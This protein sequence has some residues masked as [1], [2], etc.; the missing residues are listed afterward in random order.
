MSPTGMR[1]D[2]QTIQQSVAAGSV[3]VASTGTGPFEQIL[4]DGRHALHADEPVPVGGSDA[5][6]G[7]YELLLMAL[8][9]CTSMTVNLY[10]ARKSGLLNRSSCGF[11]TNGSMP[12]T[13]QIVRIQSRGLIAFC[14]ALNWLGH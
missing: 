2:L 11:D 5:G 10:A 8:G 1:Q 7:P 9:N 4:L 12:M 14:A 13:V 3:V 6:P